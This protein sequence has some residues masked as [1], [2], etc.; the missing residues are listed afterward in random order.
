MIFG[1]EILFY[2]V[3][4]MDVVLE[5]NLSETPRQSVCVPTSQKLSTTQNLFNDEKDTV[6]NINI[7]VN[8]NWYRLHFSGANDTHRKSTK[9][10]SKLKPKQ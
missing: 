7:A 9:L 5:K 10:I 6:D 8:Q 4:L 2:L 3:D 1:A